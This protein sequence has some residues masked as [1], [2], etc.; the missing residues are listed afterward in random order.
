[1]RPRL[2]FLLLL[3]SLFSLGTSLSAR[4]THLL[5]SDLSYEYAGTLNNP[6]QYRFTIRVYAD[7]GNPSATVAIDL[8]LTTNGCSPTAPGNFQTRLENP[9][10][11]REAL[12]SCNTGA[13]ALVSTFQGLVQ[14]P[15]A[16][17]SIGYFMENRSENLLNITTSR[18]KA[19]YVEAMLDNTIAL[20]NSSPRFTTTT[21]PYLTANQPHDYS[22]S[23][24][25]SDGDSLLYQSV[26]PLGQRTP[27]D[28][29]L[30]IGFAAYPLGS[31]FDPVTGQSVAY[32][33]RS[34]SA[35]QP[36]FSFRVVNGVAAP[37]FELNAATGALITQPISTAIG[38]YALVVRV[39][40]YR[41]VGS[42]WTHI[43][44]VTREVTYRVLSNNS[45]G[46]RNPALSSIL[47]GNQSQPL[48][49]AI[50]VAP[51]QLVML[52]LQGTDPDAG[53]TVRLSSQVGVVVPGASFQA[54]G[55]GQG[56]LTWQVPPTLPLGRYSFTVAVADNSCPTNGNAVH[57]LT[58]LVTNQVLAAHT[59]RLRPEL[60]AYP[61][62]FREQVQF[63]LAT[64]ARQVVQIVDGL[65]RVVAE[66]T[67]QADGT[68]SWHPAAGLAPGLYLARTTEGQLV[69]RLLR[70]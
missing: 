20:Q 17:W 40:E 45:G 9:I 29:P 36:L 30:P 51:G 28:C 53:Q 24:F 46:N 59:S 32:P 70:E 57:T 31:F 35:D 68:V 1:M 15:P 58:F 61:T 65:G 13:Y 41:R 2:L 44:R 48:N 3:L 10:V 27:A 18:D 33:A 34:Y 52:Q 26:Q 4:A 38:S 22:F 62:P 12:P 21:L 43:G 60:A 64:P 14:L 69:T 7:P 55:P 42:T 6:Y 49:Q 67:S 56:Q 19:M 47:L 25:D 39:D 66:L 8:F 50:R 16:R 54:T 11:T 37:Y 23:A 5:G 63:R